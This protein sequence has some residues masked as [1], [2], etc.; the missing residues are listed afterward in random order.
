[1]YKLP[2]KAQGKSISLLIAYKVITPFGVWVYP[3]VFVNLYPIRA[4][5]V[6]KIGARCETTRLDELEIKVD[7]RGQPGLVEQ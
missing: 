3:Y 4:V 1:M 5:S 2:P 6:G 7:G